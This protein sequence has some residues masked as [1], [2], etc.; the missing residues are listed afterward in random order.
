MKVGVIGAGKMGENHVRTYLS[1]TQ[2]CQFIGLFDVNQVRSNEI[3]DKYHVKAFPSIDTLLK[4]VDAISITVPTAFHYEIGLACIK[5]RVHILMEKPIASTLAQAQQLKL[6]AEKENLCFQVGH[7]E[8]FNPLVKALQEAIKEEEVIAI[9]THRMSSFSARIE[10]VDVVQDLMLHDLYILNTL[11]ANDS[12]QEVQTVGH[13]TKGMPTHAVAIAKSTKGIALQL[14]ASY[15]SNKN[16]RSIHLLTQRAYMVANL[17]TNELAITRSTEPF[18]SFSRSTTEI[19]Q[20]PSFHQPLALELRAFLSCIK[21]QSTPF[22]TAAD[23]IQAL[24]LATNISE[25]IQ[26]ANK[27]A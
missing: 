25:S 3:A 21:A 11:L 6:Q 15:Q 12:I 20:A 17:L 13:L 23:G 22:V 4:E 19:I 7:I 18:G 10:G 1:L 14:T 8:L 16:V 2:E 26:S 5:H 9:E 27:N 24:A